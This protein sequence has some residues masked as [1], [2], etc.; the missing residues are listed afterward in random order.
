[1][2]RTAI[3]NEEWGMRNEELK[4]APRDDVFIDDRGIAQQYL[5]TLPTTHYPLPTAIKRNF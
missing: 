1:M 2:M 5:P 3:D 4:Y